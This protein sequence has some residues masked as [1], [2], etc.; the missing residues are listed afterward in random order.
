M[1]D[2]IAGRIMVFIIGIAIGIWM[3]RDLSWENKHERFFLRAAAV[4]VLLRGVTTIIFDWLGLF[5]ID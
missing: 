5:P 3:V 1:G 4:L 2:V